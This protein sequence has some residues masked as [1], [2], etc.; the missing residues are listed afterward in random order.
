MKSPLTAIL[1]LL[2]IFVLSAIALVIVL[3]AAGIFSW[4]RYE[5]VQ[6]AKEAK[7]Q[8]AIKVLKMYA[9]PPNQTL[10]WR[11]YLVTN[12]SGK[13]ITALKFR[14]TV[15][16]EFKQPIDRTVAT[17]T[18]PILASTEVYCD[19]YTLFD[20]DTGLPTESRSYVERTDKQLVYFARREAGCKPVDLLVHYP[21]KVKVLAI[22]Y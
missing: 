12:T 17:V 11:F 1:K 8:V 10:A 5:A 16:N 15:F 7:K 22:A 6:T 19:I 20:A 13:T 21:Y 9:S 14:V 4:G 2:G 18:D 3:I